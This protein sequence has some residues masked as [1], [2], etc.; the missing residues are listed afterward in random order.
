[1]PAIEKSISKLDNALSQLE[2][3][4]TT[5]K[6][7]LATAA[8]LQQDMFASSM[9]DNAPGAALNQN[10]VDALAKSLDSTIANIQAL[11]EEELKEEKHG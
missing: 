10:Q 9:Q 7:T 4:I 1:M 5:K 8:S 6:T 2:T 11:L 3:A